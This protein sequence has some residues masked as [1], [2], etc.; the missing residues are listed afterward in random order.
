[1]GGEEGKLSRTEGMEVYGLVLFFPSL[2]LFYLFS[3]SFFDLPVYILWY[4]FFYKGA[5]VGFVLPSFVF[6]ISHIECCHT[7][8]R[9]T[10]PHPPSFLVKRVKEGSVW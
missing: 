7:L 3:L 9:L 6:G 4:F 1:M 10:P 2:L 5:G 8:P